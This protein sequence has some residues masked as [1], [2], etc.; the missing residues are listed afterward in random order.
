MAKKLS[1]QNRLEAKKRQKQIINSFGDD[2]TFFDAQTT[3]GIWFA[4]NKKKLWNADQRNSGF[5]IHVVQEDF[6]QV[7]QNFSNYF[8]KVESVI[9]FCFPL[10]WAV[11][12]AF[13]LSLDDLMD[14]LEKFMF[15]FDDEIR[16]Y[17]PDLEKAIILKG[18]R[19]GVEDKFFELSISVFGEEWT[20][21]LSH[22]RGSF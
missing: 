1:L 14:N 18:E 3:L 4:L 6:I 2:F 12:C 10:D 21:I 13:T 5:K 16:F 11:T 17:S 9:G 20:K 7:L 8:K 15:D 19:F 22:I